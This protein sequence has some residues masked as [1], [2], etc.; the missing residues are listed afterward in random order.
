MPSNEIVFVDTIDVC[1]CVCEFMVYFMSLLS[2]NPKPIYL[3]NGFEFL[4]DSKID[5]KNSMDFRS[6]NKL[7]L[8]FSNIHKHCA[9]RRNKLI[10]SAYLATTKWTLIFWYFN[11]FPVNCPD[12]RINGCISGANEFQNALNSKEK[13]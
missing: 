5:I 13:K 12:Y 7:I 8:F 2:R 10:E 1:V 4:I 11:T 3:T 9:K 6:W